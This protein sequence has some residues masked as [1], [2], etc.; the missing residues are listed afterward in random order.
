MYERA[1]RT[2]KERPP[3][4]QHERLPRTCRTKLG[5]INFAKKGGKDMPVLR[6]RRLALT[7]MQCRYMLDR[8]DDQVGQAHQDFKTFVVDQVLLL[9]GTYQLASK[10]LHEFALGLRK[11]ARW[12]R[13]SDG[14]K[15]KEPEPLM[16]F[17]WR[18]S[19]LGV[20][21]EQM[22]GADDIDFFCELLG[23]VGDKV[24]ADHT[25]HMKVNAFWSTI[26]N[27][28]ELVVP[29][30]I[31]LAALRKAYARTQPELH[32]RM[33]DA[34]QLAARRYSKALKQG[35]V[36]PITG[37]HRKILAERYDSGHLPLEA[38]LKHAMEA[39]AEARVADGDR[40]QAIYATW[41]EEEESAYDTFYAMVRCASATID[42]RRILEL[43]ETSLE[44][45]SHLV[46]MHRI[47]GHIR[48]AHLTLLAKGSPP[49]LPNAEV[50]ST[51]R[52]TAPPPPL[53]TAE[54][55][56]AATPA[57]LA[58]M[59]RR[60][61]STSPPIQ[62]KTAPALFSPRAPQQPVEAAS[63]A[64]RTEGLV[65]STA[66]VHFGAWPHHHLRRRCRRFR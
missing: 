9:Y 28:I 47:D 23:A 6:C 52:P 51:I 53:P 4:H 37:Y 31:L 32:K 54:E 43:F 62:Q 30:Y 2:P 24:G 41:D 45:A 11:H 55:P 33:S 34:T 8:E 29:L 60:E 18:S 21:A 25:L 40:L 56:L 1:P 13:A 36:Q 5:M 26:G 15:G 46:D 38:F 7:L 64:A 58:A 10:T 65:C 61:S 20:P 49:P 50:H 12:R 44:P 42:E 17:F 22:V 57:A 66:P 48:R 35:T 3:K 39:H 63:A 16:H 59:V 19:Q 27:P 14:S